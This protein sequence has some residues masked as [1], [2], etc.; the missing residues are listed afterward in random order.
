MVLAVL[1]RRNKNIIRV[2]QVKLLGKSASPLARCHE[3]G[4][5]ENEVAQILLG[6]SGSQ[7]GVELA[8]QS[9][10]IKVEVLVA[11]E[12][13]D[14]QGM[15]LQL[16]EG[17]DDCVEA[18]GAKRLDRGRGPCQLSL[19]G[20]EEIQ[21]LKVHARAQDPAYAVASHPQPAK[22][23]E[24]AKGPYLARQLSVF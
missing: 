19:C 14:L 23:D 5:R 21:A 11:P 7:E 12:G 20:D 1:R 4:E 18:G 2:F 3:V 22:D 17:L 24:R 9:L 13:T 10:I 8:L 6:W 16:L 15:Q